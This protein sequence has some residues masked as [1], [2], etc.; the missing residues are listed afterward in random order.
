MAR[1][2]QALEFQ[3][4]EVEFVANALPQLFPPLGGAVR[5][6]VNVFEAFL[7]LQLHDHPPGNQL[8]VAVGA[9]EIQVLAGVHDGRAGA[10]HMHRLGAALVEEFHRFPQLGSPHDGVVHKQQV[11]A[12]DQGVHRNLLHLGN[13]VPVRLAGRHE[14][15]A[16]VGVYLIKAR[17]KGMPLRLA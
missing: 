5:V 1:I 9:G 7:P 3:G 13:L 6:L 14:A 11:L 16:Q 2:T 8:H 17:A 12:P 4:G 10:A 15:A